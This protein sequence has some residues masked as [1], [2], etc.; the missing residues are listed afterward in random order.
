VKN[1]RRDAVE[2]ARHLRSGTSRTSTSHPSRTKRFATCAA[3]ETRRASR[4]RPRSFV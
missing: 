4:S 3:P 2:I 1:D